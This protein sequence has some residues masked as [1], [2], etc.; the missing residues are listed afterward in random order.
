MAQ[1]SL[2]PEDQPSALR[3][4]LLGGERFGVMPLFWRD[5]LQTLG[6]WDEAFV[7]WGAEDQAL[8]EHYLTPQQALCRCPEL[9][10]LHL[11]HGPAAGWNEPDLTQKNRDY[12]YRRNHKT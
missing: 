8:I 12:Y 11:H 7:G 1:A 3:K 5:R 4:H 10:Y 2:G 9:I 6:G